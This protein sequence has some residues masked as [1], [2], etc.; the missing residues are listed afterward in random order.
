M[1]LKI[2]SASIAL[3]KSFSWSSWSDESSLVGGESLQDPDLKG[4]AKFPA[5]RFRFLDRASKIA[6]FLAEKAL[7]P[8]LLSSEQRSTT[9]ICFGMDQSTFISNLEHLNRIQQRLPLSPGIF[10]T[11]LPNIPG[12][13]ISITQQIYGAHYT[14]A[15]GAF[16]FLQALEH[17]F[18]L[19]QKQP[20][21]LVLCGT[22]VCSPVS[23]KLPYP[24]LG[25]VFIFQ[26][27]EEEKGTRLEF[28]LEKCE[29]S[30][31]Q[32]KSSF[33]YLENPEWLPCWAGE[34][35]FALLL[36][37]LLRSK[38]GRYRIGM[39]QGDWIGGVQLS[40]ESPLCFV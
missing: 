36:A 22:V 5:N 34:G 18:Y 16:S 27:S 38:Q 26:R 37:S 24:E 4:F 2:L 14:F 15:S 10:T 31:L 23:W 13:M 39:R 3:P 40:L 7:A 25:L 19:A 8:L 28:F 9:A 12:A 21:S 29:G 33:I 6:I 17:S 1:A 30:L 35:T 20:H 32:E 11:T